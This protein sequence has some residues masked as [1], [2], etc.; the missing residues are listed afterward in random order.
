[1]RTVFAH[2]ENKILY[3]FCNFQALG[4]RIEMAEGELNVDSVISRLLD[5]K[6]KLFLIITFVSYSPLTHYRSF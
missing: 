2:H 5:G 6:N 1:M 3:F 4:G